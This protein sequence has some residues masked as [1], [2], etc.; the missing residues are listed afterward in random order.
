MNTF[1]FTYGSLASYPFQ[2]GWTVVQAPDKNKA[3]AAFRVF[4]PDHVPGFINCADV[5]TLEQFQETDM[6]RANNRGARCH[7]TIFLNKD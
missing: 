7:E 2:G 5:Y 6:F 4:H 1:I 3:V